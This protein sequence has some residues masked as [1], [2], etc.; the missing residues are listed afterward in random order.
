MV[1]S[2]SGDRTIRFWQP[3]IGRM[4]RYVRLEAEPLNIASL[5]DSSR[6]TA[7][8]VD[9]RIRVVDADQ[10]KVTQTLAAIEGWVYAIAVHPCDGSLVVGGSDGQLRRVTIAANGS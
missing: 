7:S 1:A 3:T 8:C 2:A 6:I 10:V 5:N 9:G 4:V